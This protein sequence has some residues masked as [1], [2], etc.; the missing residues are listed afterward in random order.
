MITLVEICDNIKHDTP[1]IGAWTGGELWREEYGPFKDKKTA[2]LA[3]PN[4]IN[5][6]LK[7][8]YTLYNFEVYNHS[9]GQRVEYALRKNKE[10]R[11]ELL[12]N[13]KEILE[14]VK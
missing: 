1:T 12:R 7:E 2:L 8:G 3:L 10:I 5:E 13:L 14:K 6:K 11:M 9:K 4:K